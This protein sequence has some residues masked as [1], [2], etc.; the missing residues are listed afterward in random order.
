[1]ESA[2]SFFLSSGFSN[3]FW[4]QTNRKTSQVASAFNAIIA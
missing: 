3:K 1:M 4:K 2:A